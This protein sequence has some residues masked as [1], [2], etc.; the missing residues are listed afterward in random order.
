MLPKDTSVTKHLIRNVRRRLQ[1]PER[2]LEVF[3]A[4]YQ[5]CVNE[6][7]AKERFIKTLKN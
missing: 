3:T 4:L 1:K 7:E 6:K 2:N 5:V